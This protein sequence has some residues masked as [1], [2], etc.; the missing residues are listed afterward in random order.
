[1]TPLEQAA[2]D[3]A[4][5]KKRETNSLHAAFVDGA[6]YMAKKAI[7]ANR[8]CCEWYKDG[9]CM[10]GNIDSCDGECYYENDFIKAINNQQT[11]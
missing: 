9:L 1:M 5:D 4:N 10:Y 6:M 7:E 8:I 3:Y 11:T 2:H